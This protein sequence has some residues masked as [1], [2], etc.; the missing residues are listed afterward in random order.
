MIG[1]FKSFVIPAK[2][3]T[4]DKMGMGPI[5][6]DQQRAMEHAYEEEKKAAPYLHE[7][8]EMVVADVTVADLSTL[9]ALNVD[10]YPN[11]MTI[12]RLYEQYIDIT[13]WAPQREPA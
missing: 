3:P 2:E 13:D 11:R 4:G 5:N 7:L 8:G 10:T 9:L 6:V 12:K 1:R